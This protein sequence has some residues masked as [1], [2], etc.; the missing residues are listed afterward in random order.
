LPPSLFCAKR[1]PNEVGMAA[2]YNI[3]GFPL[4]G[5]HRTRGFVRYFLYPQVHF[6]MLDPI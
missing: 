1:T 6:G 3:S 5:A 2:V 4:I